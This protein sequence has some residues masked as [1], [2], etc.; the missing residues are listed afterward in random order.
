M[1]VEA[2]LV[3]ET[4]A[5]LRTTE[6]GETATTDEVSAVTTSLLP[7]FYSEMATNRVIDISA[8]NIPNGCLLA[9]AMLVANRV[10]PKFGRP[11]D[12]DIDMREQQRLRSLQTK[13]SRRRGVGA[14]EI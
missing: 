4:L 9:A 14:V 10:A 6:I 12:P 3:R 13:Y 7:D 5:Y 1:A 2:D 8:A 11:R